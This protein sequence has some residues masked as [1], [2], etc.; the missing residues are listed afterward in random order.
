MDIRNPTS[1][2][3][4]EKIVIDPTEY[5]EQE[6]G[7][8]QPD[9]HFAITW[10]GS[11]KTSV[12]TV[13]SSA[14]LKTMLKTKKKKKGKGDSPMMIRNVTAE[15]NNEYVPV[16]AFE[17]RGIEP[18]AFYPM[19]GEFV[20]ESEGGLVFEGDDVDFSDDW[21][22]YDTENDVPVSV[23]EFASKFGE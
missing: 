9:H 16:A 23:M 3:I 13:L 22:D 20:V 6:E 19:G 8:K 11:K 17:T 7:S 4:R 5:L 21:A 15:D 14:E 1:D 10:E 18:F 2:E 12:L